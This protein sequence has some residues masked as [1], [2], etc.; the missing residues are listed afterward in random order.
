MT[1]R[2]CGAGCGLDD[3]V[4]EGEGEGEEAEDGEGE[5][6][7]GF[8][9]RLGDGGLVMLVVGVWDDGGCGGGGGGGDEEDEEVDRG[10]EDDD[11]GEAEDV[12]LSRAAR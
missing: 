1:L 10:V 5:G 7:G 2:A 3:L 6:E 8:C 9:G 4:V 11:D 12:A